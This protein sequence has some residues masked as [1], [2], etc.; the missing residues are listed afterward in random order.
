MARGWEEGL[1]RSVD[2]GPP[3]EALDEKMVSM[4]GR[5]VAAERCGEDDACWARAL[6]DTDRQVAARGFWQLARRREV[7]SDEAERLAAVAAE[8]L[9]RTE[10]NTEHDLVAGAIA[11][12][13]RLDAATVRPWLVVIRR[14]RVAWEGRTNPMGLPFDIPLA[15]AELERRVSPSR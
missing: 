12:M 4:T 5:L 7:S 9:A 15:L 10:P 1:A 13:A 11:L 6:F 3:F 14:A 2:L 8:T